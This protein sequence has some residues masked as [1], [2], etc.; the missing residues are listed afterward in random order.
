MV[1]E[2]IGQEGDVNAVEHVGE[3]LYHGGEAGDDGGEVLEYPS[4]VQRPGVVHDRFETQY[5]FASATTARCPS[6]HRR[7]CPGCRTRQPSPAFRP[8]ASS[9]RSRSR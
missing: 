6:T 8:L 1:E 2:A 5:V 7:T 4:G 9:G 3:P